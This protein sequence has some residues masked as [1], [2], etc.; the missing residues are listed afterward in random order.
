[1]IIE[2]GGTF[3]NCPYLFA[4]MKSAITNRLTGDTMKEITDC[5]YDTTHL[6]TLTYQTQDVGFIE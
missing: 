2:R 5:E 6:K 1:M 3:Y 4:S